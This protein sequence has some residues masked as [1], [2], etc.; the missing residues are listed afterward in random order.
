MKKSKCLDI[1]IDLLEKSLSIF[2]LR[3]SFKQLIIE[4]VSV[5][6][7]S[8]MYQTIRHALLETLS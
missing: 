8:A 5:V 4:K 3:K 6:G 1:E 2:L 7:F